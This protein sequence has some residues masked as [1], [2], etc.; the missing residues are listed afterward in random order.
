MGFLKGKRIL[1]TGLI[2]NRS[3]AYGIAQACKREGATLAFTY[4]NERI[5]S[6]VTDLAKDFDSPLVFPCDVAEDQQIQF[7]FEEL[8]THWDGLEGLVHSVAFAPKE[9]LE[10]DYLNSVTRE[11]FLVAHDISSYSFA[12]LAKA[13]RSLLAHRNASLLTLSYLGAIRPVPNYNVM[14]LAKASLEANVRYMAQSLGGENIR[15]NGIS[16]GPIKTLAASG[17]SDF[18]KILD[19]VAHNSPLKRNVTQEEVGNAAAFLLSDL[20]S[21]I[22]GEITYV[23]SGFNITTLGE[24]P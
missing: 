1:I 3:I 22:T 9:A 2:S 12:A 24:L 8:R 4:Q 18:G 6:R 10:G 23:D 20:A 21:G 14:G 11:N 7:L 19:Y 15:V 5:K 13:A 16:A 17:I